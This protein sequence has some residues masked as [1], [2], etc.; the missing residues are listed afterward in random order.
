MRNKP[1]TNPISKVER[2]TNIFVWI[3]T[4]VIV[5]MY[6]LTLNSEPTVTQPGIL[7]PFTL[8]TIIHILLHWYLGKIVE[9]PSRIFW[10]ILIQGV[11]ALVISLFSKNIGM[12]FALFMGL[13]GEAVGLFGLTRRGLLATVYY[14]VLLAINFIQFSGLPSAGSIILTTILTSVFVITYVTLYMRQNEARE[15]AQALAS[16]LE[17]ANRQLSEYAAQVEDLTI[18]N[19]R[20]RMARELHDT[21]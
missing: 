18:A 11:L 10:Y 5:G 9:H 3:M 13:L 17:T 4:L 7:I 12:T 1:N 8:L 16:D 20:Q 2:D 6:V 15:Q 21:L 19:E 14:L